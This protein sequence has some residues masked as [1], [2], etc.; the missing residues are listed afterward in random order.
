MD[1]RARGERDGVR[2]ERVV[3]EGGR[4]DG[5]EVETNCAGPTFAVPVVRNLGIV[6]WERAVV[7]AGTAPAIGRLV[8]RRTRRRSADGA[9]VFVFEGEK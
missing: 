6:S 1:V 4:M 3:L 9:R 2:A 5:C 8:Y 7:E